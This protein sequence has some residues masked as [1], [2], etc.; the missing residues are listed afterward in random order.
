MKRFPGPLQKLFTLI[1]KLMD[2]V[3][4]KIEEHKENLDPAS[5]K[6]YIDSFLIEMEK[7]SAQ[8]CRLHVKASHHFHTFFTESRRRLWF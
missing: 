4:V 3:K 1:Q 8:I 6:D 2:F 7:V 5:P